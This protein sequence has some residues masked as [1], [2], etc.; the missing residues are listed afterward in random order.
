MA[1]IRAK[2]PSRLHGQGQFP[3]SGCR[4]PI[5]H[6]IHFQEEF[7]TQK[8]KYKGKVGQL[9][10]GGIAVSSTKNAVTV[11]SDTE[12]SKRYLKYLTKKYL[13]RNSLREFISCSL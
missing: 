1:L 12:F 8:I 11:N 10:Q 5:K 6:A 13:K 4:K 9:S 2:F 3:G 7:L